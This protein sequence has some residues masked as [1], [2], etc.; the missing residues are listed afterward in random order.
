MI[1][2]SHLVADEEM[3]EL[4]RQTKT[5]VESI[6]FSISDVLDHW[7][8]HIAVYKR[9]L[10]DM[11]AGA[12]TLHGPFLDLNPAAWDSM[13]REATFRRF[14]QSYEAARE[15]GAKKIVYH[16]CFYPRV[17]FLEG[18]AE[19][20]SEFLNHFLEG[21]TDIEVALENVL[22]PKWEPL[23]EIAGQVE[24]ENF[25]LC[26]DVGHANCYSKQPVEMWAQ[27]LAP[28]LTHIHVHDN[29]G[30]KDEHLALGEGT[31]RW[32]AIQDILMQEEY[33]R[34]EDA[35]KSANQKE[36]TYTIECAKK[37]WILE[38][39]KKLSKIRDRH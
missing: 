27:G 5:G 6:D 36:I 15:L 37:E 33:R 24:A 31:I 21:R 11:G 30:E 29:H 35:R 28:Y 34:K 32:D 19:R 22:D 23:K 8:E 17:Y 2:V 3:Q 7:K 10:D 39:W 14:A 38:S 18:W 16:S 20:V 26:L 1:Y 25:G 12:L 9:R 13:I 4:I